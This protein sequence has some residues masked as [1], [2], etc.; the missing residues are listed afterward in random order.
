M[1]GKLS[2]SMLNR[3]WLVIFHF[4]KD[5]ERERERLLFKC[6]KLYFTSKFEQI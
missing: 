2:S 4:T 3:I 1:E 6:G 5:P